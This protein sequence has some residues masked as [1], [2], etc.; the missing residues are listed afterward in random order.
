MKQISASRLKKGLCEK[1]GNLQR[2]NE[3]LPQAREGTIYLNPKSLDL[4]QDQV[5]L[6]QRC[7][8]GNKACTEKV[9]MSCNREIRGDWKLL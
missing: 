3:E 2:S 5:E 8:T 7:E 9:K 6:Q 4:Q 1:S